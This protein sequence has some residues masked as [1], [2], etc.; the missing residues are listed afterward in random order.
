MRQGFFVSKTQGAV[1]NIFFS[2]SD[3]FLQFRVPA[4]HVL[5][6]YGSKTALFEK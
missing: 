4:A 6:I 2:R 3:I 5:G 1:K